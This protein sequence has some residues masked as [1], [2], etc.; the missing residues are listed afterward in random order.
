MCVLYICKKYVFLG[1]HSNYMCIHSFIHSVVCLTTRPQPLPQRVHHRVRSG[2]SCLNFQYPLVS[3][4]SSSSCLRR[5]ASLTTTCIIPSVMCFIR[6][7]QRKM[8]PIQLAFLLL[9]YVG[10]SF[11]PSLY[12]ILHF[13]HDFSY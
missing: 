10:Y 6:Q 5:L 1:P 8:Q 11:S 13:S 4:R 3:L 2:A 9:V 7:F 12:V